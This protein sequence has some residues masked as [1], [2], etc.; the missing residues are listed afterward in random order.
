MEYCPFKLERL[1]LLTVLPDAVVVMNTPKLLPKIRRAYPQARLFIWMHCFPGKRRRKLI[2]KYAV[3]AKAEIITVSDTLREHVQACLQRY[4]EYGRHS[5]TGGRMAP[6][7]TLFNPVDDGLQPNGKAVDPHKL[8]F[9]SSPHKGLEQV[10]KAFAAVRRRWPAMRLCLANPGY[11]PFPKNFSAEAVEI[12]GSLTHAEVIEHVR[13][14]LCVFYPQSRF[15]ETFGLVFAEANAVGTPVIT[16]PLGAS[17]EVLTDQQ[18]LVDASDPQN[19]VA[20]LQQWLEEGRPLVKLDERF[21]LQ[22]VLEAWEALLRKERIRMQNVKH[23]KNGRQQNRNNRPAGTGIT[24]KDVAR[25]K[26][27]AD[28][29]DQ[30]ER[31]PGGRQF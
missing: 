23:S 12:L 15:K 3:A 9:F 30:P 2:N 25:R 17:A 1:H 22:Q 18:Q 27:R 10:L 31:Y 21:R 29:P 4:P 16:H 14:A 7:R 5:H 8:V 28:D 24:G 11:W 13:E 6:V 19:V 26:S 20:V